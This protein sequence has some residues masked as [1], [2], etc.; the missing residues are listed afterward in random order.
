MKVYR[1][2]LAWQVMGFMGLQSL[3]Y[4]SALSWLPILLRDRGAGAVHAGGLL[5]LM[6]LGNAITALLAPKLLAQR[7]GP[8]VACG[9]T[10][11]R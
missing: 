3:I 6:N 10:A 11:S 8:A 1:H 9:C 5:A 4:Y 2:V 7:P